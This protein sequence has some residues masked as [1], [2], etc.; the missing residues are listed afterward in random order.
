MNART[1]GDD[2]TR[3]FV[4]LENFAVLASRRET[5]ELTTSEEYLKS[6]KKGIFEEVT[7]IFSSSLS[8]GYAEDLLDSTNDWLYRHIAQ[9]VERMT[10]MSERFEDTGIR[11]RFLNQAAREVLLGMSADISWLLHE[12]GGLRPGRVIAERHLRNF[13]TFYEAL[14]SNHMSARWLTSLETRNSIFPF[15]NYR[16]FRAK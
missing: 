15:I 13:T 8:N 12:S 10:E 4:F 3:A 1:F 16:I 11:E 2:W 7:P 14:G 6:A 5:I 9:S